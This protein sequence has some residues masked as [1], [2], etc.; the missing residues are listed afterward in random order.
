MNNIAKDFIID[1][2]KQ[3]KSIKKDGIK[4]QIP[5]IL[6]ASRLI[7]PLFIIPPIMHEK[8]ILAGI[9]L[10]IFALTDLFDGKLARKFNCVSEFGIKLDA[11]CDK[12]FVLGISI[13]A[14]YKNKLLILILFIEL[15]ISIVNIS[16]ESIGIKVRS[17]MIGKIKTTI[18][19][20]T[21]V[22]SYLY[23]KKI[24]LFI[25]STITIILQIITFIKY[26]INGKKRLYTWYNFIKYII[27]L[28]YQRI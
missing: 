20:I 28:F 17:T 27:F 12:F 2:K 23:K 21:L 22:I 3:I 10:G 18:L 8:M 1:L 11:I 9:I 19:S 7:A 14:I 26:I 16:F 13:P 4:R 5:N 15:L 25:S 24:V 6:T